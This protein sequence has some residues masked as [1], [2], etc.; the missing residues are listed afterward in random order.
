MKI[1]ERDKKLL[2]G[3]G[4]FIFVV[5]FVRFLF[6][7][8]IS[9]IKALNEELTTLNS[10]YAVNA[11]YKSK[12]ENI[13]SDIKI[14]SAKLTN[15]RSV[16]PPKL[17]IAE[18]VITI[19]NLSKDSKLELKSIGF[20]DYKAVGNEENSGSGA[21]TAT[22]TANGAGGQETNSSADG[23]NSS[24]ETA[25]A[26]DGS[27]GQLDSQSEANSTASSKIKNYFYL[28]GL[29]SQGT[30][31]KDDI[32]VPDGKPYSVSVKVEA[33]G[34]NE[35]IKDFLTNLNKLGTKAY[36]NSASISGA[37]SGKS[38]DTDGK[39]KLSATITFY[40][41]MDR[42]T[43]G[44]YLLP[45]GKWS[46]IAPAEN[47]TNLFKEY[48]GF[49]ALS[50]DSADT[51][52]ATEN[53]TKSDDEN[54]ELAKYDFYVVAAA[55][56]GGLAPSV[57]VGCE[58]PAAKTSYSLPVVYGDSKGIEN[59]EIFIEKKAGKYYCKFKTD[60][61]AYPDHEYSQTFEFIPVGKDLRLV[62]LSS[63]RYG[64]DDKAGV[65]LNIINNTDKTL[66]YLIKYDDEKSPRVKIGKTTGSVRN[67]K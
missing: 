54:L 29:E 35:Q 37:A 30:N 34:T 7:P 65:N 41:I 16:Y 33:E 45:D 50:T 25:I 46:P 6:L 42:A 62:I 52:Y 61:E 3:L 32:E 55:F 56:G 60:H 11:A 4:I 8:K 1:T 36:C 66:S 48:S 31:S 21:E 49:D 63:K 39:L 58:S 22:G 26:A 9:D 51:S 44:Y 10:T 17:D 2:I 12:A 23:S 64:E 19:K 53:G 59:A 47:K 18:L 38:E 43:A 13:D 14:L 67:E 40:G 57:S 15:L 20:E 5:V 24:Q 28:W 27:N